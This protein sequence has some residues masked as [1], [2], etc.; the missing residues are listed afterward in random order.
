[1]ITLLYFEEYESN[2]SHELLKREDIL[3]IIIRT[4]KNMKFFSQD[5]IEKTK[6]LN[7][8]VIDYYG[9]IDYEVKKFQSWLDKKNLTINYFLNDSEYYMEFS[10]LFASKLGLEALTK[11]QT[12]WV[13]DKVSMKNKFRQMGLRTVD[14]AEI[15]SKQDLIRFFITNNSNKIVLKPR[16]GMNSINTYFI[17]NLGDIEL[18]P[19]NLEPNKYMA[20]VFTSY[21]EW[22][23]ESLI[24]DGKVLD[25]YL[26]YIPQSTIIAS[27]NNSLNCHMQLVDY[28]DYFEISPKEYIQ[29]IV[30]GMCLKNGAMTIEVFISNKGEFY[31]SEMGWRFPGC[32]T[33]LNISISRG[34]NIYSTLI[35]IMIHKKVKLVYK[36]RITYPGD[37]YL[38]NKEGI[39][40]DFTTL[41]EISKYDGYVMGKLFIEKGKY[42]EKKRVG[43][44]ASGWV[45][46]ESD[47]PYKTL[48]IMKKIFENYKII[49]NEEMEVHYVRKKI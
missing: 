30:D 29:K 34:F 40:V 38:P 20:E 23:I 2:L 24:Q 4:N 7:C 21:H 42:Q 25:S 36:N 3:P 5:Y 31:A 1:M 45:I 18:L 10:N 49:T 43:T 22:S 16:K 44:D 46:V 8:Y 37:L 12:E 47:S 17:E 13:R 15:N 19:I 32:Q 48:S 11:E 14:Y 26:T 41:D 35:D 28:P 33:P 39:I 9:N 27:T 6:N